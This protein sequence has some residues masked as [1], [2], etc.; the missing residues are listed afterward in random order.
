MLADHIMAAMNASVTFN[1]PS[2]PKISHNFHP[3]SFCIC[4][5]QSGATAG[6]IFNHSL[7]C[8]F[9]LL[10]ALSSICKFIYFFVL[11]VDSRT[12]VKNCDGFC[13]L[14][15]PVHFFFLSSRPPQESSSVYIC[16]GGGTKVCVSQGG[17]GKL[18]LQ[19]S[20]D[21]SGMLM[22]N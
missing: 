10:V 13:Y 7:I 20:W 18:Y 1:F 6:Q 9:I 19:E 11:S 14:T 8:K 16:M 15:I 17:A 4:H 2:L 21:R 5:T 3:I 22:G 12:Q